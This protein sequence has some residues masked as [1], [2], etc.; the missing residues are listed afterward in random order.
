MR[1]FVLALTSALSLDEL[2]L[3]QAK[4][5]PVEGKPQQKSQ[6]APIKPHEQLHLRG[7]L[8]EKVSGPCEDC[9]KLKAKEK[10]AKEDGEESEGGSS[11]VPW[12]LF[13][14]ALLGAG[15]VVAGWYRSHR[16][17]ARMAARR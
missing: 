4:D 15:L 12:L 8:R 17:R 5:P 14:A 10:K 6:D 3:R 16:N 1:L 9:E 13:G 11:I 2:T 7:S